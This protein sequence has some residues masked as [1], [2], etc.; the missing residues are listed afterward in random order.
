MLDKTRG[1][2]RYG[3]SRDLECSG[4][5]SVAGTATRGYLIMRHKEAVNTSQRGSSIVEYLCLVAILGVA[6]IP[7][8]GQVAS[9]ADS[10]LST[11]NAKVGRVNTVTTTPG[12]HT[13]GCGLPGYPPCVDSLADRR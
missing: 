5:T 6:L 9:S 4:G 10:A 13:R 11:F 12:G 8:T 7:C 1:P 2:L 3:L